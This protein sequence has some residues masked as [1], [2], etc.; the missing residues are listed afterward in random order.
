MNWFSKLHERKTPPGL[1]IDVLRLLPRITL[2][3]ALCLGALS[4]T[5]RFLPTEAGIDVAKRTLS[6]D[7]F[8]IA[9]GLTFLSIVLFVALGAFAVHIMKGPAYVADAYPVPHSDEPK[10]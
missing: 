9:V 5:G 6:I 8:A 7:I 10:H 4:I 2:I 3:G 1:E